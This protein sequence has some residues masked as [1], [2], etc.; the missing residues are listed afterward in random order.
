[1]IAEAMYKGKR[2]IFPMAICGLCGCGGYDPEEINESPKGKVSFNLG[3]LSNLK[4][5]IHKQDKY[6]NR[7]DP[8]CLEC[9]DR[10]MYPDNKPKKVKEDKKDE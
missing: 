10:S 5:I 6:G 3:D 2:Y 9:V 8:L 1:M 4:S 7:Y